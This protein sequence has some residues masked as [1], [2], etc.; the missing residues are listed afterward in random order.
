MKVKKAFKLGLLVATMGAFMCFFFG[1]KTAQKTAFAEESTNVTEDV[2]L[3]E[4][5]QDNA[6]ETEDE[7]VVVVP[8]EV[9]TFGSRLKE[10]FGRNF[11]E[12]MSSINLTAVLGCVVSIIVDKKTRKKSNAETTV[13]MANTTKAM[14]VNT[15]SNNEVL[16]VVNVLI[17]KANDIT[18]GE[19][20]CEA[21]VAQLVALNK[22]MIDI[23]VTLYANNKNIPQA[24]KDIV[25]VK[26]ATAI[27]DSQKTEV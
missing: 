5:E 8:K 18:A 17:D 27:K 25:N 21:S 2:E 11:L 16:K 19:E 6:T 22:A 24:I 7:T 20:S 10:W 9:H 23:L 12:F 15:A 14:E 3:P 26:Y 13:A 4:I 1:A